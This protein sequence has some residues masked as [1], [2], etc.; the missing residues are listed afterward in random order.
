MKLDAYNFTELRKDV[1]KVFFSSAIRY[2]C[3]ED[4]VARG[5]SGGFNSIFITLYL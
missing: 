2:I 1:G 3:N 4:G 5:R